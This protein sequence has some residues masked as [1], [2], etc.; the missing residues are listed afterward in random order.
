MALYQYAT[1][2]GIIK[3]A[4]GRVTILETG[5]TGLSGVTE[6]AVGLDQVEVYVEATEAMMDINLSMIY[7]MPL[8]LTSPMTVNYLKQIA[9]NYVVADLID[10][11]YTRQTDSV[12][13]NDI[14]STVTRKVAADNFQRLF[15][16]T[17]IFIPGS[18]PTLVAIQNDPMSLQSQHKALIL[19]EEKLKPF[20][21]YDTNEDGVPDTDLFSGNATNPNFF[22]TGVI[23]TVDQSDEFIIDN[24]QVRPRYN[25][26]YDAY[27]R[28]AHTVNF[29]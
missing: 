24:V 14:F 18:D 1:L 5:V 23:P 17:G 25:Q 9:E 22:E 11:F 2:A 28:N 29:W 13:N 20:I 8:M 4:S 21:G 16:G 7:Y 27:R 15:G 10:C 26:Y 3:R 19:P 12:D 6:F